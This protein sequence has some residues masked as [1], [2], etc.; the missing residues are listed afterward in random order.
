MKIGILVPLRPEIEEEF[1]K[2]RALGIESC[3]LCGWDKTRFT[4]ELALRVRTA[5][6]D[7]GI[8]ITAFWCGWEGPAVWNF[9]GGPLTLGIV[10]PSYRFE[11][12]KTLCLGSD[13]AK[14]MGVADVVTHIGFVP[15][16][17]S[18]PN[19]PELVESV[20]FIGRH[21]E[22]NGQY[23]LF[24]TGQ[25]TPITLRRL[26]EDTG[27]SNLG[28]NLDPANLLMYGK[29]NPI[30]ALDIFGSLVRGVH[31]K[32]GEYPV[33]GRELGVEKAMGQGRVHFDQLI[34]KLHRIGYAGALTIERE[35]DG[36][37]QIRDIGAAK[38]L[39]EVILASLQTKA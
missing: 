19:Y 31:A 30:D 33:N 27:L 20:R 32:D 13:F 18:D 37:E 5:A 35:I 2:M 28:I 21:C 9:T 15:E 17:P 11:R 1:D 38:T 36:E 10:Q 39:L 22:R 34:A 29:A 26:I 14:W 4:K 8:D 25:E 6:L 24:E 3:Q 23:F 7:R 12:T 16:N